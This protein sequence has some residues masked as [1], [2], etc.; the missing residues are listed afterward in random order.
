MCIIGLGVTSLVFLVK[1]FPRLDGTY[2]DHEDKS[3]MFGLLGTAATLFFFGGMFVNFPLWAV[4]VFWLIWFVFLV[5]TVQ[6]WHGF[7][8][9]MQRIAA[10]APPFVGAIVALVIGAAV[11][12]PVLG[13]PLP[14]GGVKDVAVVGSLAVNNTT[15]LPDPKTECPNGTKYFAY[16]AEK[17]TNNMGPAVHFDA[18]EAASF[19]FFVKASC[20]PLW[21]ATTK[22]FIKYSNALDPTRV[23]AD[24]K[25]FAGDPNERTAAMRFVL[26]EIT[27]V[28]LVDAGDVQYDSLGMIPGSNPGEMPTLTKFARQ[29][30]LGQTLVLELKGGVKR[31]F[32]GACDLQPSVPTTFTKVPAPEKPEVPPTNPP[33]TITTPPST[34]TTNVT[35]TTSPSETTKTTPSTSTSTTSTTGS[36]T[37]TTTPPSSTT[38]TSTTKSTTSTTTS[39]TTTTTPLSSTTTTS[40]KGDVPYPTDKPTVGPPPGDPE[41]TAPVE[42][43]PANPATTPGQADPGHTAPGAT[44][45][46]TQ[47]PAPTVEPTGGAD[48]SNPHEGDVDPDTQPMQMGGGAAM[49]LFALLWGQRRVSHM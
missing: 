7:R 49:A 45:E 34:T 40:P 17:G 2:K 41:P 9:S 44:Q 18:V 26:S 25:L 24:A 21:L 8:T 31:M 38:T 3:W 22:H 32:R 11:A 42:P 14:G 37:T 5:I 12:A 39:T 15:Q 28:T 4:V 47:E 1:R 48:P 23:V 10:T 29:P 36:S 20:D 27:S 33:K 46:P 30:A 16:E 35:T 13:L 6:L 43:T 19:R